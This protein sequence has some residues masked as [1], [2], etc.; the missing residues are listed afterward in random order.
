MLIKGLQ[1]LTLLDY[2]GKISCTVFLGGCNMRC[3]FCH[4]ST[5]VLCNT[6]DSISEE[7]LLVFLESRVGRL[8]G[9]C[10]SGGEPTLHHDLP[11]LLKKIKLL[12]FDVKLDTN[13]TNPKMLRSLISEGLVDYVAMDI[14]NSPEKYQITCGVDR[15][16][17]LEKVKLSIAILKEGSIPFEFRTTLVREL[18]TAE[19]ISAIGRWLSGEE[20][21]YLQSY[22]DEGDLLVGGFSSY[23]PEET[24]GLL[25]ILCKYIKN[26]EIRS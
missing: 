3:P 15:T 14:K 17:I 8:S 9:V 18:H 12:G 7:E 11:E 1:K 5:L 23:T 19:D 26:A 24:R 25:K 6:P 4:N 10:V 13:G 20:S 22:R 2:P 21:Y 16:D